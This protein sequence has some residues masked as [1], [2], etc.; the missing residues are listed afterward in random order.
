M[1][2]KTAA[3]F[4]SEVLQLFDGFVGEAVVVAHARFLQAEPERLK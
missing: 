4:P 1:D 2:R 3:E